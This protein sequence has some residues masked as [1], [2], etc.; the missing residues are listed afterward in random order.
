MGLLKKNRPIAYLTSVVSL[1]TKEILIP[2]SDKKEKTSQT[3]RFL[4]CTHILHNSIP[5]CAEVD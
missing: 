1:V 4:I 5:E 3:N 2:S